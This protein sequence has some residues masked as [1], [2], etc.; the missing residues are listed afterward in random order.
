MLLGVKRLTKPHGHYRIDLVLSSAPASLITD[1][2][3]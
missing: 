3:L 2:S 1:H